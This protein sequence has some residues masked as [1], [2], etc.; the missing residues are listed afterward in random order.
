MLATNDTIVALATPFGEGA[1][2]VVRLSGPEAWTIGSKVFRR[3]NQSAEFEHAKVKVGWISDGSE[4]IDEVMATAF[5][6]PDTYTGED[7]IEFGCHG[8]PFI[9]QRIVELLIREGARPAR[10]GEFTE[11]RFLSGKIDL[12]QAEAVAD[13]VHARTESAR[14]LAAYGLEGRLS[15]RIETLRSRLVES[16]ALLELELDFHEEDVEFASRDELCIKLSEIAETINSLI[17]GFDRGRVFREGI[18]LAIVGRPNVGKSSLLNALLERERAIVT[19]IPGTT[20]DT[21]E[22]E[23]DWDGLLVRIA[24]TAGL[25]Q[26]NEPIE[27][28]GVKRTERAI[29]QADTVLLVCDGSVNWTSEDEAVSERLSKSGKSVIAV[30]N[31]SDLPKAWDAEFRRCSKPEW[32][33][34]HVS[35]ITRSGIEDLIARLK[36][37]STGGGLPLIGDVFIHN[38]RHKDALRRTLDFIT[39]AENALRKKMSQE[40]IAFDIQGAMDA[41]GEITGQTAS[42]EILNRIFSS[43]CIGK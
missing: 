17:T 31:K 20:R 39:Q 18:R 30:M 25:R 28:E 43:F 40:F 12:A 26:T 7:L 27:L 22:E 42:E 13:L 5:K 6:N 36:E 29:E 1:L 2:A 4:P 37:K 9:S 41:L 21:V 24:D 11:R 33:W 14:R 38:Q 15:E 34:L 23:M 19:D 3:R 16:C 10:A 35:A 8:G 32:D